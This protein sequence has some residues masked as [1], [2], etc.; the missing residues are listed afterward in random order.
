MPR[1]AFD[2]R[3]QFE[4]RTR[5]IGIRILVDTT[6][7]ADLLTPRILLALRKAQRPSHVPH[8]RLSSIGDDIGYLRGIRTP[9]LRV[10]VLDR[11]FPAIR[12][13]VHVDVRRAV[14]FRRKKPLEQQFVAN[15]IDIG[16]ADRVTHRRV[17]SGTSSLTEDVVVL[18]ERHDVMHH[19][20]VSGKVQS[21]DDGKF[22]F[23]LFVCLRCTFRRSV[24]FQRPHHGELTQPRRLGMPGWHVER[25]Q[26]GRD[27]L[28]IESA[29]TTKIGGTT[30]SLGIEREQ[31]RHLRAGPQVRSAGRG[32]P[33]C[34]LVQ[35]LTRPHS[36]HC[37]GEA[38]TRRSGE[39]RGGGRH[40]T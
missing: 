1:I 36:R 12:L 7:P 3:R 38:S 14:T 40:R 18:A 24:A 19:Q 37:H 16:D 5:N 27:E 11:L 4:Y 34:C 28:E 2:L 31:C 26:F 33:S 30:D 25:W 17:R 29:L 15:R 39:V 22:M 6:P 32:Q 9:V 23:E 20:E 10:H 21:L 13:D 35:A 8:R